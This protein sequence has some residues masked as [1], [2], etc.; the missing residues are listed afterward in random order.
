MVINII[1]II[2]F[3]LNER[4]IL[5]AGYTFCDRNHEAKYWQRSCY[6]GQTNNLNSNNCS[7]WGI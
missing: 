6:N 5:C 2:I 3:I 4:I 1:V 7:D